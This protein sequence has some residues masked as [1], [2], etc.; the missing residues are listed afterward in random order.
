MPDLIPWLDETYIV[1]MGRLFLLGGDV[2]S[3]LLGESSTPLLPL[4]YLGPLLQEVLFRIGGMT[5]VRLGPF[6]GLGALAFSVLLFL[7]RTAKLSSR[8]VVALAIAALFAP[9]VF[10]SALL[11]RVDVWALAAAFAGLNSLARTDESEIGK[12]RYLAFGAFWATV[13]VFIWPTAFLFGPLFAAFALRGRK[14]RDFLV[15]CSFVAAFASLFLLPIYARLPVF[16]AGFTRHYREVSSTTFAPITILVEIGRE[17]ARDPLLALLGVWGLW[18]WIREKRCGFLLA[19]GVS[20]IVASIAGLYTFRMV[21]LWPFVFL[22]SVSALEHIAVKYP[23]RVF[24]FAFV[25]MAYAVLTGPIGHFALSHSVLP[26][27]AKEVLAERIGKGPV[28]VFAP[29]HAAYYIGRE[30]GWKQLGFANP[31]LCDRPEVLCPV[32]EKCDWVI[33]REFDPEEPFQKSFTPY[34]LACR[35][36]LE[37]AKREGRD[38]SFAWHAPLALDGFEETPRVGCLRVF[39]RLY[40]EP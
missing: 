37:K 18:L 34:G 19:F 33:L 38:I 21:Y 11:T 40:Q 35:Y 26:A 10:Q 4:C 39:K 23:K 31:A 27:N 29:D 20:F 13:S 28:V 16:L 6:V 7:R 36:V 2:S 12:K 32:L 24:A 15:F 8:V 30:L 5:A 25:W 14:I 17:V 3:T 1:E 22:S 9:I